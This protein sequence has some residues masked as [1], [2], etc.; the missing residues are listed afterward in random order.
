MAKSRKLSRKRA[1]YRHDV[2]NMVVYFK[3]F[4]KSALHARCISQN[5]N[6]PTKFEF[7]TTCLYQKLSRTILVR[8]KHTNSATVI[9]HL[10]GK[11]QY[12]CLCVGCPNARL[13]C[14]A[15]LNQTVLTRRPNPIFGALC[16][17]VP[18]P[19][20]IDNWGLLRL[21]LSP[22]TCLFHVVIWVCFVRCHSSFV[23]SSGPL[24]PCYP[25]SSM[26]TLGQAPRCNVWSCVC[27]SH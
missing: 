23:G 21:C 7:G 24:R 25:Y 27:N 17:I 22:P 26:R 6:Q 20:F 11:Q 12:Q 4:V 8:T 15:T 5:C 16:V 14:R 18:S 13:K 19:P 1:V 3:T 2:T 10:F 9:S